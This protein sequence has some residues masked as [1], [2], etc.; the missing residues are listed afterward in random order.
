MIGVQEGWAL[1]L[2]TG[3]QQKDACNQDRI[4]QTRAGMR[5]VPDAHGPPLALLSR[6]FPHFAGYP[7]LC[8]LG[9]DALRHI[10]A[11]DSAT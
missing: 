9:S 8:C 4:A 7:V 11:K 1:P 2:G 10:F 6:V 5:D 3:R